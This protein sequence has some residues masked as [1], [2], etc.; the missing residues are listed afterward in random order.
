MEA[1]P[2]ALNKWNKA[3]ENPNYSSK[4]QPLVSYPNDG[5]NLARYFRKHNAFASF[6]DIQSVENKWNQ[7]VD[8]FTFWNDVYQNDLPEYSWFTPDIWND[9]HYV[10][11]THVT[12]NPRVS[13]VGQLS[14]WLEYV[15]FAQHAIHLNLTHQ[16]V[17][18]S[19]SYLFNFQSPQR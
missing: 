2:M 10:Y 12:T 8:E 5:V 14:A 15:F 19:F 16:G 3:W 9:G 13:L 6:H 11:N 17:I 4:L 7:I 18:L 1:Y